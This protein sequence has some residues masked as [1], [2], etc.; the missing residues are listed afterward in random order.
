MCGSVIDELGDVPLLPV[1]FGKDHRYCT[2][3]VHFRT[4]PAGDV[5]FTVIQLLAKTYQGSTFDA[6]PQT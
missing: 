1:R 6:D 4:Q 3:M 2:S 5:T